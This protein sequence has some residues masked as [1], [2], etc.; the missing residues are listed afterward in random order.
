M[1]FPHVVVGGKRVKSL[2]RGCPNQFRDWNHSERKKPSST[3]FL[4]S[5]KFSLPCDLLVTV[6][7]IGQT[8]NR[9]DRT[10]HLCSK[11]AGQP[12]KDAMTEQQR[13]TLWSILVCAVIV[14]FFALVAIQ[15]SSVKR[16]AI[17]IAP[18]PAQSSLVFPS[19]VTNSFA[20][21]IGST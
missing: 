14:A 3:S 19:P 12:T 5:K 15:Q 8:D 20:S 13:K 21:H 17:G 16:R 18:Q 9:L 4:E 11:R 6:S 10:I 1:M 2:E 7:F